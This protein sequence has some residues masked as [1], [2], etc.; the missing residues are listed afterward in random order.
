E[1]GLA[2]EIGAEVTPLGRDTWPIND[3]LHLRVWFAHPLGV[4]SAGPD[5]DHLIW[6]HPADL[7]S[8]AWLPADVPVA[9]RIADLLEDR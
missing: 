5:H 7:G 6:L 1:L 3:Q 8:I 9:A 2:V 4:P